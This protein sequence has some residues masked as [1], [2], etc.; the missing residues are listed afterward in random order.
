MLIRE[1]VARGKDILLKAQQMPQAQGEH[2]V[3]LQDAV[4]EAKLLMQSLLDISPAQYIL[5]SDDLLPDALQDTYFSYIQ[6]R[7]RGRPVAYILGKTGFWT[8][9]L[10]SNEHTLIPRA[11]TEALVEWAINLNIA[12][13]SQVLDLGTGTG[14]IALAIAKERPRWQVTGLDRIEGAVALAKQN[15]AMNKLSVSFMQSDWFSVLDTETPKAFDL[16]VSNPPYVEPDSKYL[17]QGDLRFEPHSALIAENNGMADIQKI[18]EQAP[19]HLNS[20][21]W[22]LIEHGFEQAHAVQTLFSKHG[23][24]SIETKCDLNLQPRVTGGLLI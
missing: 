17:R 24:S 19:L 2:S 3:A 16:I 4:F 15:A 6:Q 1:A 22:L 11:D 14:A 7:S 13:Q 5:A 8:L 18:V 10:L 9:D 23:F 12:E 21:G 20:K